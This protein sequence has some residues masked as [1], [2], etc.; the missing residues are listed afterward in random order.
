MKTA[1][2]KL[3]QELLARIYTAR[4]LKLITNVLE[5]LAENKPFKQHATSII[6]DP[7]LAEAQKKTQMLYLLRSIEVPLLYEFF[8]DRLEKGDFWLFNAGKVDYFDK[9]VREVQV[10]TE[11]IEIINMTTAVDLEPDTVRHLCQD[12]SAH[13]GFQAVLNH[14]V[15]PAILGGIQVKIEN[16]VYDFTLRTKFSQFKRQWLDSLSETENKVGRNVPTHQV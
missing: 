16:M 7:N 13:F 15:N 5:E 10:Q 3:A 4:E 11:K 12:L 1:T 2:E 8:T 9:F 6:T 14:E